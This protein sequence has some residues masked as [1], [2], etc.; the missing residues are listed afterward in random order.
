MQPWNLI[1][2]ALGVIIGGEALLI[3]VATTQLPA[4]EPRPLPAA[5]VQPVELP[6]FTPPPLPEP[7]A[8]PRVIHPEHVA[9]SLLPPRKPETGTGERRI[10]AGT[11]TADRSAPDPIPAAGMITGPGSLP[12]SAALRQEGAEQDAL[13]VSGESAQDAARRATVHVLCLY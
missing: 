8:L 1:G 12:L 6:K 10:P 7:D 4:P 3:Y 13:A 5:V 11:A 9:P 2:V